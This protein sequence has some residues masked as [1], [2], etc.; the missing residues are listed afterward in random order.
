MTTKCLLVFVALVL[1]V[2]ISPCNAFRVLGPEDAICKNVNAY[3]EDCENFVDGKNSL[4]TRKCCNNLKILNG[5]VKYIKNGV[6]RFCSC[7]VDFS[8]SHDHPPYLQYR[9]EQ[10]YIACRV[11]LSFPISEHMD[12]Y[13]L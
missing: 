2:L 5:G 11:H 8:N 10:L 12:C 7:I 3:F 13:K 6:R 4:P 1:V 9:I